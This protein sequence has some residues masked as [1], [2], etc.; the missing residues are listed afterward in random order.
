MD[1][2]IYWIWLSLCCSPAGATF[3]KLIKEFSGAKEIYDADD[4][5]IS[6]II[7]YRNSDRKHFEDKSLDKAQEIYE[8][9]TKHKVGLLCYEDVKYPK[10]LR[11]IDTPPVLLYYRGVLPDFDNIFPVSVVGTRH[12]SDYG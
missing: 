7:G 10:S 1:K 5:K 6:S 3:G 11:A 4:K 8:F 12:L 9:C 2:M